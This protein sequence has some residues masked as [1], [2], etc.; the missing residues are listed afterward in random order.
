MGE[1][2]KKAMEKK[3]EEGKKA[4]MKAL[5]KQ[6]KEELKKQKVSFFTDSGP[7]SGKA[8]TSHSVIEAAARAPAPPMAQR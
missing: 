1:A 5:K 3:I 7:S 2:D 8:I 4:E 6:R